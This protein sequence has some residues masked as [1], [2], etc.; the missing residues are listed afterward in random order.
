MCR[1]SSVSPSHHLLSLSLV[2][3]FTSLPHTASILSPRRFHPCPHSTLLPSVVF[4]LLRIQLSKTGVK[5][6]KERA[7]NL[8]ER[9]RAKEHCRISSELGKETL[10]SSVTYENLWKGSIRLLYTLLGLP[11]HCVTLTRIE[12][13]IYDDPRSSVTEPFL[14]STPLIGCI[15]CTGFVAATAPIPFY[16]IGILQRI[17]QT[18][19]LRSSGDILLPVRGV[20]LPSLL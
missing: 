9:A 2:S 1:S 7:N 8:R 10:T 17:L 6:D 11:H 19:K 5:E 16:L 15:H 18:K 3:L 20:L 4:H 13:D 12:F 14:G